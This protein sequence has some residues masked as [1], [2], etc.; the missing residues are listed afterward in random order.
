MYLPNL[1][2]FCEE[3]N[4][5]QKDI[6]KIMKI[7]PQTVSGWVNYHDI[8][9]LER[10]IQF[11]NI[12]KISIDYLIGISRKNN[13]I[14]L[15][16]N[17]DVIGKRLRN[18]RKSNNKTIEYVSKKINISKSAYCDYENGKNL[19]KTIYLLS[20]FNLYNKISI[21]EILKENS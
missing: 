18:L 19:I 13:Y 2:D 15:C 8:I 11:V 3:N 10:L 16:S 5:K 14:K 9:P 12:F 21:D 1:K 17:K 7:S 4:I 20:L 6:A